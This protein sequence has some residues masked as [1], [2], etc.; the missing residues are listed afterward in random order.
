MSAGHGSFNRGKRRTAIKVCIHRGSKEIGGNCVE[1]EAE[2]KRI[3]LDAGLPLE[4]EKVSESE[5]PPVKGFHKEDDS[6]LGLFISHPHLDHSGLLSRIRQAIPVYIGKAANAIL[7]ASS[8]FS[9][10]GVCLEPA[11]FLQDRR[12]LKLGP[13]TITPFLMDHSAYDT[14][15]L[16]VEAGGKK[17]FYTA[18]FRGH[19]RKGRLLDKLIAD[20]PQKVDRLLTEGTRVGKADTCNLSE[21][22]LVPLFADLFSKA[23]GLPLVWVSGQNID[24][25]VS[26][27]KACQATGKQLIMDMYAAEILRSIGNPSLPQAGWKNVRVFLP[28]SQRNQIIQKERY[29]VADRFKAQRIYQESLRTES[30]KS[31]MLFR[32]SMNRDMEKAD[33][34]THSQ[35]V[36]SVWAGYLKDPRNKWFADWLGNKQ[37]PVHHVHASG[38]AT[39]AD[40]ARLQAAFPGAKVTPM[41]LDNPQAFMGHFPAADL[42]QDGEWWEI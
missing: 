21:D 34:L 26:I 20:P 8:V 5:L 24:R 3:V 14:Y 30:R 11:G 4:R 28:S 9:P 36:C 33:C 37:L 12:P 1:I 32:P 39:L 16:L 10:S 41:H 6:F 25:I 17:L 38:H 27:F 13:F 29:D 40:L 19:G 15:A 7:Q 35:L 23:K 18:D 2:G 31:V 42:R 22:D